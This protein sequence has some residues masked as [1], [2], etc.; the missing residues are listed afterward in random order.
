MIHAKT[1][2]SPQQTAYTS[3]SEISASF[4]EE[5]LRQLRGFGSDLNKPH[6]FH[7]FLYFASKD[8]AQEAAERARTREFQT[9]VLGEAGDINLYRPFFNSP[10][11]FS[12]RDGSD[13]PDLW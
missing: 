5:V 2:D 8:A 12:H 11:V 3:R 10:V 4:Q 7:F 6:A 9:H 1:P 13:S